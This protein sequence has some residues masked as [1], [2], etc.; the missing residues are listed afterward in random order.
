MV[1]DSFKR[2]NVLCANGGNG[3]ARGGAVLAMVLAGLLVVSM[4][5]LVLVQAVFL[6]HRQARMTGLRQQCFWLAEAGVQ[7]AARQLAESA[8][9]GGEKWVVPAKVLGA[10][11]PGVVT[12]EVT[13]A[14]GA[15]AASKVCVEARFPD[16]AIRRTVCQRDLTLHTL[17]R[18]PSSP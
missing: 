12:I 9:Y 6:H 4:L 1:G 14:D 10:D 13:K 5:A 11:L 7:R 3:K 2:A 18:R 17:G 16:G 8:D 15:L